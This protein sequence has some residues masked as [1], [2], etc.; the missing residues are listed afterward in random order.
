MQTETVLEAARLID[1]L[2]KLDDFLKYA[3]AKSDTLT[4][5][6]REGKHSKSLSLKDISTI[7]NIRVM[8]ETIRN[9]TRTAIQELGVEL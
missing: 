7:L 4:I 9:D 6:F 1:Q 5:T 3:P 2:H 8:V